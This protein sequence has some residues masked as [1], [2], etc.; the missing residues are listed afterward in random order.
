MKLS[1][2]VVILAAFLALSQGCGKRHFTSRVVGGENAPKHSWPWQILLEA[3]GRICGGS[4]L[5]EW[6]VVT[7]AHCVLDR[8]DYPIHP[9]RVTV[10]VGAHQLAGTTSVQQSIKVAKINAHDSFS[11]KHFKN[12]IALIQLRTR[13]KLSDK[14]NT[15]CLPAKGSRVSVGKNCYVTGWGLT[16]GG[17]NA[18]DTLQQ[19]M[20]PVV[21]HS[22]C[23]RKNGKLVPDLEERS[24][25]CAGRK[26]K[27]TC[28]GDSG[29]PFVCNEGGRWVLRGVVSWGQKECR[30]DYYQV[31]A[32]VSSF[33]DWIKVGGS[34][35][36]GEHL[37]RL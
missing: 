18:A 15:V 34:V 37:P 32:R 5:S 36:I 22:S 3:G 13:V 30:T 9:S 25:L 14:V 4:L 16:V 20:L 2:V 10:I 24:M 35:K 29:G 6:W 26:G 33:V 8:G 1:P 12:D 23:R 19:V 21:G 31:F 7:A 11:W 28:Q 17:G 27:G